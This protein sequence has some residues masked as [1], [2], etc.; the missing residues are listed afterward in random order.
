MKLYE[1]TAAIED[2]TRAIAWIALENPAAARRFYSAVR[3]AYREIR[4]FPYIGV[5]R[6]FAEAGVR[7]WRIRGFPH[8]VFYRPSAERVEVVR[9]LHV[10]M[11]LER[12]LG[13]PGD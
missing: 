7:S 2:I 8:L 6:H 12:E 1:R 4:R 3:Q 9:V 10:A 13:L 5:K 11:D